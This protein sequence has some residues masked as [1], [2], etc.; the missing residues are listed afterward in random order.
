MTGN[1][2]QGMY[3]TSSLL[4]SVHVSMSSCCYQQDLVVNWPCFLLCF[5]L[6]SYMAGIYRYSIIH[7]YTSLLYPLGLKEHSYYTPTT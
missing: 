4:W 7:H 6:S 5:I 1:V 2:F 3:I